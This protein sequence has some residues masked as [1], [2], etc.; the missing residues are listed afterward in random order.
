MDTPAPTTV[1]ITRGFKVDQIWQA[2]DP[3]KGSER[4]RIEAITDHPTS[5]VIARSTTCNFVSSFGLDGSM[6]GEGEE[7]GPSGLDLVTLI[8]DAC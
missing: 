4:W 5:P 6:D 1:V 2:R 7:Y 3:A 8:R